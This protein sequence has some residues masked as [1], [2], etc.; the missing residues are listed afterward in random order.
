MKSF[1]NMLILFL[2]QGAFTGRFPVAPGTAGTVA[3]VLI[4]FFVHGLS[5]SAYAMVCLVVVIIGIWA[6]GRAEDILGKKDSPSIVVDEI[7]GYL[8]S[9]FFLPATLGYVAAGFCLFRFFDIVKPWPI[10]GLQKLHGGVG[11]MLDDIAAG[12]YT[13][14]VLQ[15]VRRLPDML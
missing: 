14:A 10:A 2:A 5:S 7:A 11:V 3:A 8:I 13:N 4:Y 6:A 9:M 12:I 15:L 1:K